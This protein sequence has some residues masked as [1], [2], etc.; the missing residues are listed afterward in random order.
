L[1]I[2]THR[3]SIGRQPGL[4][5]ECIERLKTVRIRK[6]NN[7]STELAISCFF[8][9]F[10]FFSLLAKVWISTLDL[11]LPRYIGLIG[12]TGPPGFQVRWAKASGVSLVVSG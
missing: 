6:E 8:F 9:L 11:A 2:V 12:E 4:F 3:S 7:C 10:L 5:Q 1:V